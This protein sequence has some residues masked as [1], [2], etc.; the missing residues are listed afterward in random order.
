MKRF[1][2]KAESG[3]GY[4]AAAGS[5]EACAGGWQGQAVDRLAAF[6]ALHAQ[7]ERRV[8]EIPEALATLRAQGKEKTVRFRELTGEKM[9]AQAWL[10]MAADYG[11]KE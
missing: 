7:L 4:V 9:M 2:E 10:E 11:I 8:Q 6:E 3:K 1:T 5:V